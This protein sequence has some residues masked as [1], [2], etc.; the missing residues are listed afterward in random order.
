MA[1]V[2]DTAVSGLLA[3]Q[4]AL[5]VTSNNIANAN[6]P[7]YS[8][9]SPEFD[10][11]AGT[12]IGGLNIGDGVNVSSVTR[13]FNQFAATNLWQT[14]AGLG[15]QTAYV[16]VANSVVNAV[17]SSTNGVATALTS[18]FNS[19]QTLA[20]NPTS[21]SAQQAV[22]AQAQNLAGAIN[23]S[24]TQLNQLTGSVNTQL[25]GTVTGINSIATQIAQLNGEIQTQTADASGQAPNALLDQRDQLLTQLGSLTNFT[26]AT[27]SSGAIDVFIGSGQPL[28]VG[29]TST[30]LGTE[31]DQYNPTVLDVTTG[32]GGATQV[33]SPS[34]AGGQLGGLLQVQSQL[35]TPTL[36]ALGEV[37]TGLAVAV[38]SQQAQGTDQTGATGQP[39]FAIAAPV[40][41]AASSNAGNAALTGVAF[42][43][44]PAGVAAVGQLTCENYV[45]R[46]TGLAWTASVQGSGQSA[47]V[48]TGINAEGQTTLTVGGATYTLAGA[49]AAGDTFLLQPT[50]PAA[51][52]SVSLTSP[53]GL[54]S[55][56]PLATGVAATNVGTGDISA[57]TVAEPSDP[58][59]LDPATITFTSA[60]TY[61]VTTTLGPGDTVTSAPQALPADGVITA[62]AIGQVPGSGGGWSVTITGTPAAND[63]FTV[64]PTGANSGDNTNANAMAALLGQGL[65]NGGS[66]GL[67]AA[68]TGLIGTVANATQNATTQQ[69]AQQALQTQAQATMSNISGVN[70]DEEAANMLQW[71][72]AYAAAGKVV[73]TAESMFSTLM[74]DIQD[75]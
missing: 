73:A 64:G 36:G 30:P 54:A 14:T 69:S 65:F 49:P 51:G 26:T 48:T 25:Q 37:A 20:A 66:T 59:L 44:T 12:D 53:L 23:S 10:A 2:F 47:P 74:T 31:P 15:Q 60:T 58:T 32:S 52:I 18:F 7:G 39:I 41:S 6:T 33:L 13:A 63:S 21:S 11:I 19:W 1:D 42:P 8:V 61:T 5:A 16:G 29:G 38:N 75:G 4:N 68:Y 56:G 34:Q 24:A 62:P 40:A 50:A 45:L 57:P 35:I 3:F 72:N 28:V 27:E 22:L 9:E 55:A 71:Q 17:G 46:F 67:G 70:L 43:A